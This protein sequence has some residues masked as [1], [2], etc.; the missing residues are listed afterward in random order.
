MVSKSAVPRA[1]AAARARQATRKKGHASC[2]RYISVIGRTHSV[3][4][5]G[6]LR[7][8]GAKAEMRMRM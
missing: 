6:Y 5:P 4:Q 3:L 7:V 2:Q 8:P 1:L